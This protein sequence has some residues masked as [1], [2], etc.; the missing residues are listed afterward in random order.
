MTSWTRQSGERGRTERGSQLICERQALDRIGIKCCTREYLWHSRT[1]L[2]A[3]SLLV[4]V[5]IEAS[6][7]SGVYLNLDVN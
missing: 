5:A 3:K 6:K 4:S 2:S 7:F 1:P